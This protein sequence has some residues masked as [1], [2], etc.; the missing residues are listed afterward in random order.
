MK[1]KSINRRALYV[2]LSIISRGDAGTGIQRVVRAIWQSLQQNENSIF[3]IIPVAGSSRGR[4]RKIPGDC[5]QNPLKRLPLPI[6]GRRISPTHG[7]VFLGLDLSTTAVTRNRS[8]LSRWRKDGA[9]LVFTV[10]DL[11]PS[12]NPEWFTERVRKNF[13]NW[14][15][16]VTR[17]ADLLICISRTVDRELTAWAECQNISKPRTAIIPLGSSLK[18]DLHTIGIPA[19]AEEHLIWARQGTCVLMVGTVE[20]RKGYDQALRAFET[21][22]AEP[23]VNEDYRLLIVGKPGWK[24]DTLQRELRNHPEAGNR[25][26]WI[27]NA[28]DEYLEKLY[29]ASW[30]ILMASRGEGFGLP[31]IEAANYAKP[32]LARDLA[33]FREIS[34]PNVDFFSGKSAASL[35]TAIRL[36]RKNGCG[37]NITPGQFSWSKVTTDLLDALDQNF[38][39]TK[40]S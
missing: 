6:W 34:P 7:D 28:S 36:W 35:A 26:R 2:D 19:D 25:L 11:L 4:Y 38:E 18:D 21:L 40:F 37:V 27:D 29:G 22:W 39:P 30:G 12:Q 23:Q 17:K 13:N 20:P 16:F 1:K 14:L 5:L 31:L 33:I 24:T 3:E 9:T 15:E 8:H 10:Y 32:I